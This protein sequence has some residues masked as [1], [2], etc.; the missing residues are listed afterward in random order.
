MN[1][2]L[3]TFEELVGDLRQ[4]GRVDAETM[5]MAARVKAGWITEEDLLP[6]EEEEPAE[7]DG[8]TI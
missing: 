2:V 3:S 5:I 1:S 7:T 6:D 4:L 8:A